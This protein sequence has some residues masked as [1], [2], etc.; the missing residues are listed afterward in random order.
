M[1][2]ERPRECREFQCVW[3]YR[4]IPKAFRP[5]KTGILAYYVDSQFG[6][7]LFMTETIPGAY[8]KSPG[9]KTALLELAE[10]KNIAAIIAEFDGTATAMVP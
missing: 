4:D 9:A 10:N 1:Y 7:T 2:R 8:T 3:T 6:P 5:D